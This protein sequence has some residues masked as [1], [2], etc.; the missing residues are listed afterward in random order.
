MRTGTAER[1]WRRE[2]KGRRRRR[3]AQH[4]DDSLPHCKTSHPSE[5]VVRANGP[6]LHG[7]LGSTAEDERG[8][9]NDGGGGG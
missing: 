8:F 1:G 4:G 6:H 5:F 2:A 3:A 7:F 9:E